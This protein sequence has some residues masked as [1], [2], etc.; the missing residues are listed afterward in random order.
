MKN[1][2]IWK[3]IEGY[4]GIYQISNFGD[5]KSLN[6]SR[7]KKEHTLKQQ[8]DKYGYKRVLLY[9]NNKSKHY[10]IHRLV[11]QAFI[12]NPDNLPQINHKDENRQNNVFNNLEWCD[13]KYNNNYG[14][15]NQKIQKS[16]SK[17]IKQL[18]KNGKL[19][20]I[21]ENSII[22]SKHLNIHS[23][24]IR[25]CCRHELKTAGGYIWEYNFYD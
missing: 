23:G 16:L 9:K 2:E 14:N 3:D 7:T 19:I 21:W 5:V 4:E 11:A 12:P 8:I 10:L 13:C 20:K 6:Y 22:A 25:S 15:R 17:E 1:K 18:D 24:N